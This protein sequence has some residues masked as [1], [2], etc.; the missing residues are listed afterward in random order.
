MASMKRTYC[1]Y[2]DD[3]E[4]IAA[5][6]ENRDFNDHIPSA[7]KVKGDQWGKTIEKQSAVHKMIEDL[8]NLNHYLQISYY[9]SDYDPDMQRNIKDMIENVSKLCNSIHTALKKCNST[10][11]KQKSLNFNCMDV[12]IKCQV[13]EVFATTASQLNAKLMVDKCCSVI[14]Y[15]DKVIEC[16]PKYQPQQLK[17][18]LCTSTKQTQQK[19]H[20]RTNY[21]GTY[22]E[23][24]GKAIADNLDFY[25]ENCDKII[26]HEKL[27]LKKAS[28]DKQQ[29]LQLG[30]E[31]AKVKVKKQFT[32][33]DETRRQSLCDV[34]FE[35]EQHHKK[36]IDKIHEE[37]RKKLSINQDKLA[38]KLHENN[39]A[40]L[41]QLD[42]SKTEYE[43]LLEQNQEY[44]RR[45]CE[46]YE[47]QY[48]MRKWELEKQL[49]KE[50]QQHKKKLERK[51][52]LNEENL[53]Q[54]LTIIN[55][56]YFRKKSKRRTAERIKVGA[57]NK[58]LTEKNVA[59]AEAKKQIDSKILS[60]MH[61]KDEAIKSADQQKTVK[62]AA[63]IEKYHGEKSKADSIKYDNDTKAERNKTDADNVEKKNS[64]KR[65]ANARQEK[66][67][68]YQLIRERN[69]RDSENFSLAQKRVSAE[70]EKSI[71]DGNSANKHK[72]TY[73]ISSLHRFEL[74]IVLQTM[75]FQRN[76][77]RRA[78]NHETYYKSLE[79]CFRKVH[80]S[81]NF[82]KAV[83]TSIKYFWTEL[84]T[85][86]KSS[87]LLSS[88]IA[89][90]IEK[91]K[92]LQQEI[93]LNKQ[94]DGNLIDLRKLQQKQQR[95][96][97]EDQMDEL[98]TKFIKLFD[99]CAIAE[100]TF[101]HTCNSD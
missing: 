25:L 58:A 60:V 46:D 82:V 8:E 9:A 14:C 88:L 90:G 98:Y 86:I 80:E 51:L 91:I 78:T 29:Q 57:D 36:E 2:N 95:N 77:K 43:Q 39:E 48:S 74:E 6:H 33:Y 96:R 94:S 19:F 11:C 3:M 76:H 56:S 84:H 28:H 41:K 65:E 47:T 63:A 72:A 83:V 92:T 93:M 22:I 45:Q 30:Y 52:Q 4:L 27:F 87:D 40:Y 23:L 64:K 54:Q 15:L 31:N 42:K 70:I 89:K 7:S 73:V 71:E 62:N 1:R 13:L 68:A 44:F 50:I 61:E 26:N 59:D 12:R 24:N 100:N 5:L 66:T 81:L 16:L 97:D 99:I 75:Q 55:Q 32:K 37:L 101:A 69:E 67:A 79:F 34:Y 53:E 35:N 85:I 38:E 17:W 18:R 10:Y 20:T 21:H 49:E